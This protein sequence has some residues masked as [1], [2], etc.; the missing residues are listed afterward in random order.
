MQQRNRDSQPFTFESRS[1]AV[2]VTGFIVLSL[3]A[4]PWFNWPYD[5]V[6][7]VAASQPYEP[8]HTPVVT[9]TSIV[10]S[11]PT[12]TV[13]TTTPTVTLT[14]ATPETHAAYLPL[15]RRDPPP[16]PTPTPTPWPTATPTITPIPMPADGDWWGDLSSSEGGIHFEVYS[17]GTR[18]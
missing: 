5:R 3:L 8:T 17:Q 16:P 12:S 6:N 11:T 10:T 2:L 9:V 14:P 7:W 15:V 4:I 18:W 13:A 1:K